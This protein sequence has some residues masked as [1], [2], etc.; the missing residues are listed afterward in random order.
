MK[1]IRW[2][3]RHKIVTWFIIYV[4]FV[5]LLHTD[6]RTLNLTTFTQSQQMGEGALFWVVVLV[7]WLSGRKPKK[8]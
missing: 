7:I 6:F 3:G 2:F 8:V 4:L 1:I 5:W